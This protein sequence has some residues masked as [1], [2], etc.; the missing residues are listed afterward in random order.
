MSEASRTTLAGAVLTVLLG[1]AAF[2]PTLDHGFVQDDVAIV[3]DN[4]FVRNGDLA[5][6]VARDYSAGAEGRDDS[7][8][9]P[10]LL[11][12]FLLHRGRGGVVEAS[13]AHAGNL[14]LHLAASLLVLGL[15]LRL[16]AGAAAAAAGAI[17]FAVH[18]AHTAAVA[19]LVGRADVLACVFGLAALVLYTRAGPWPG[20]PSRG[21]WAWRRAAWG[22]AAC[23][24]LAAGSKEPGWTVPGLL[25]L[26]DLF[27]RPRPEGFSRRFAIER[28]ASLAPTL[29]AVTVLL[30]LR[31]RALGVFPG[32]QRVLLFENPIVGLEGVERIATA[33]ACAGRYAALLAWPRTLSVDWSGHA[34]PVEGGIGSPWP[35]AGLLFLGLLVAAIAAPRLPRAVS[36]AAAM[37]LLPYAIVSNLF[38]TAGAAFAERFVYLPSAGFCLLVALLLAPVL[39]GRVAIAVAIAVALAG[40]VRTRAA[41]ADWRTD[42]T[43]FEAVRRDVPLSP[44]AP[45]ALARIR[46][47]QGRHDEALALLD[48]SLRLW[49]D[50]S[51]AWTDRAEILLGRGDLA[52]AERA[53]RSAAIENPYNQRAVVGWGITL[54]KLDRFDESIRVLRDARRRIPE[55][56]SA[57]Q[58][59]A[60][61][62]E[63]RERRATS[64][65]RPRRRGIRD[66]SGCRDAGRRTRARRPGPE[67]R[68]CCPGCA[69]PSS[70]VRGRSRP[71]SPCTAP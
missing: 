42:E 38:L 43:L 32:L 5:A 16:G 22:T 3:R 41:V 12:T 26:L 2:L 52:G 35:L 57:P 13:S 53:L 44:R 60:A 21:P 7:L 46:M 20:E 55:D 37:F 1:A 47:A 56:R 8:Y 62:L 63:E 17:L 59:L 51:V 58:A 31:T 68:S 40:V 29:L 9:R 66:R 6:I 14:A 4:V 71:G 30:V 48:D 25:V 36:F 65:P 54:A 15:A 69:P 33:L 24:F 67:S 39:R 64:R 18:P 28:L 45:L 34:I 23:V 70:T 50:Q 11:A 49:P 27:F 10:V 19:L 61:V